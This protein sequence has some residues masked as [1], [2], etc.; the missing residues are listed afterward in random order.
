MIAIIV[1]IVVMVTHIHLTAPWSYI[2]MGLLGVCGF[3]AMVLFTSLTY[4]TTFTALAVLYH[5]QRLRKDGLMPAAQQAVRT[6]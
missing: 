3:A 2:G 4:A 6:T 1:A 5:D